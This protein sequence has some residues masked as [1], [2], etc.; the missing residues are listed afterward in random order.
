MIIDTKGLSEAIAHANELSSKPNLT[1]QEERRYNFL[2]SA[3]SAI[4]SGASFTDLNLDFNNEIRREHGLKP[5]P[6][7][8]A[9]LSVEQEQRAKGFK[10]FL[11]TEKTE[12]RAMVEAQPPP[13]VS[14]PTPAWERSYPPDGW[15]V[16]TA[17]SV[18]TTPYSTRKIALSTELRMAV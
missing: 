17:R 3:I 11:V 13:T 2:L 4:K 15:T 5:A 6:I 1:K 12:H 18:N 16:C 14:V 9:A 7:N 10:T 8:S